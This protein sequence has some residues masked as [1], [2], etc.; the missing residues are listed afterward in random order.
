[1]GVKPEADLQAAIRQLGEQA[2]GL[3]DR[4]DG[5]ES[6]QFK[7]RSGEWQNGAKNVSKAVDET[8]AGWR[9]P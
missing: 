7:P 3:T 8:A 5:R 6:R 4:R 2:A 9:V 1:M